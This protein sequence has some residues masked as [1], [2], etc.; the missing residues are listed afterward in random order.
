MLK[1]VGLS[2]FLGLGALIVLSSFSVFLPNC[3]HSQDF[4]L[5]TRDSD[6]LEPQEPENFERSEVLLVLPQ[7][8]ATPLHCNPAFRAG[9]SQM[10]RRR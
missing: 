10:R 1:K 3:L 5:L 2:L 6:G 9:E 7:H 8:N 4:Q